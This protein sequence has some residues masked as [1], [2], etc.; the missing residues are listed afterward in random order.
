M[1]FETVIAELRALDDLIKARNSLPAPVDDDFP[2]A[3]QRYDYYVDRF[4]QA[5]VNNDRLILGKNL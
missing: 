4:L 3:K 1:S 5:C 2:S